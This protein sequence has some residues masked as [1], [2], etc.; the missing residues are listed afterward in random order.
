VINGWV[1]WM[2]SSDILGLKIHLHIHGLGCLSCCSCQ[3]GETMSLNCGHQLAYCSFL[4]WY[5]GVMSWWNDFHR[6]KN[7]KCWEKTCP[8][9]TLSTTNPTWIDQGANLGLCGRRPVTNCLSHGMAFVLLKTGLSSY[10]CFI[11]VSQND[12][13]SFLQIS[14]QLLQC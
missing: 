3:W 7:E 2:W 5:V 11:L 6:R 1:Y 13:Y 10:P 9:A 4:W 8:S 12:I 14:P